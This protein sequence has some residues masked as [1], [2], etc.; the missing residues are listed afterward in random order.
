MQNRLATE[1]PDHYSVSDYIAQRLK[2][3]NIKH[4]FDV[5]GDFVT[6]F[7]NVIVDKHPELQFITT[8]NE[9]IAGY[10]TDAYARLNGAAAVAVTYGVGS[11]SLLNAVAGS[12]VE[13][14]P[15]IVLNGCPSTKDRFYENQ[16]GVLIHHSTGNFGADLNAYKNVTVAA[17]SVSDPLQ[18][19][20]Q[21]DSAIEAAYKYKRPCYI[22]VWKD[23][24]Q[25]DCSKPAGPLKLENPASDPDTL[26]AAVAAV[27]QKLKAA[28]K[29][30][31]WAGIEIQR[32]G[33]QKNFKQLLQKT[34]L[35]Y[36]TTLLAK[37]VIAEDNPWFHGVY[38]GA[39]CPLPTRTLVN[40]SDL[41]IGLG[42]IVT[43][44]YLNLVNTKY[45][46][47]IVAYDGK[48]RIGYE[49]YDNVYLT[50][51]L[52][53]L[54][55]PSKQLKTVAKKVA[56]KAAV[57][58]KV[59]TKGN[60]DF[61]NFFEVVKPWLT[62]DMTVLID[63]SDSMYVASDIH[64]VK[65][66]GFISEAAWG[67]IGYATAAAAGVGI[68]GGARPV[69]FAGDGGFHMI[70]QSIE[71][72]VQYCPGTIVFVMNNAIFGIEQALIN[73]QA[74]DNPAEFEPYNLFPVWKYN[75][76][77]DTFGA[78]GYRVTTVQELAALLPELKKNTGIVS[79]VDVVIPTTDL[80]PQIKRLA[81][82]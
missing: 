68:Y 32:Y 8:P 79:L 55:A 47:M 43:D 81:T 77:A 5:P 2:E 14:N 60:L 51:L 75:A 63:E 59:P 22:E 24:W 35:P 39:P 15:V 20:A 65:D 54:A 41:L 38:T 71:T 53:A 82:E 74:F 70:A 61:N 27:Q 37:G 23:V 34:N 57:K 64:T 45:G 13:R 36:V 56:A 17:V 62:K 58:A 4:I 7:M 48:L 33:L 66:N 73:W 29:P 1:A 46:Q 3:L 26:K 50:D 10:A 78:K 19:P 76:L 18:A 31:W 69:V 30:V 52:K 28:K 40:Q 80:P 49:T 16:R 25:M 6:N 67:S 21:I 12:F 9:L 11:F 72:L 42:T 44:D